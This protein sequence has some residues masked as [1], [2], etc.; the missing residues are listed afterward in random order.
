MADEAARTHA[1]F[2][3]RSMAIELLALADELGVGAVHVYADPVA[4][5]YISWCAWPR[6]GGEQPVVTGDALEGVDA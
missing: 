4:P 6:E 1:E 3:L 2:A 5:T